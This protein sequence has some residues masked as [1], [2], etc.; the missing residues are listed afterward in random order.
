[1][2]GW[3]D[4]LF[5]VSQVVQ[6]LLSL[7][8]QLHALLVSHMMSLQDP[9]APGCPHLYF[10]HLPHL[11]PQHHTCFEKLGL[12]EIASGFISLTNYHNHI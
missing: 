9:F 10:S 8:L 3:S 2:Q 6:A 1:M 11:P 4:L 5:L 7:L 12:L